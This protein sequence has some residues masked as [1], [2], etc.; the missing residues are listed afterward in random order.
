MFKIQPLHFR[1]TG[2]CVKFNVLVAINFRRNELYEL[3]HL[4]LHGLQKPL[5]AFGNDER[6]K[7]SLSTACQ[8]CSHPSSRMVHV[9]SGVDWQQSLWLFVNVTIGENSNRQNLHASDYRP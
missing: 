3:S 9:C 4:N 5:I 1:T 8:H 2:N 7:M 6:A